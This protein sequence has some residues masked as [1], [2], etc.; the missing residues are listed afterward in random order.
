MLYK[1]KVPAKVIVNEFANISA[2][3]GFNPAIVN[4]ILDKIATSSLRSTSHNLA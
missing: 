3:F 2:S 1:D 4:S